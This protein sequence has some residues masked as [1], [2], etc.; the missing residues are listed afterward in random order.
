M[1][2]MLWEKFIIAVWCR[3]WNFQDVKQTH[4]REIGIVKEAMSRARRSDGPGDLRA[5]EKMSPVVTVMP[6]WRGPKKTL[7]RSDVRLIQ[8]HDYLESYGQR[9]E[10]G[11][12]DRYAHFD[13]KRE[14]QEVSVETAPSA[15]SG[16]QKRHA[17]QS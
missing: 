6:S 10:S 11:P 2:P 14:P 13:R 5:G 12:T 15:L 16:D 8:I 7:K 17:A 3:Y 1:E 4:K 9:V